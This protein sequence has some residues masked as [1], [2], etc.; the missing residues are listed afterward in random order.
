[1]A[2]PTTSIEERIG[3]AFAGAEA[4]SRFLRWFS[5]AV[6]QQYRTTAS[7]RRS[8]PSLASRSVF[9]THLQSVAST[10]RSDVYGKLCEHLV[11]L[12]KQFSV[13]SILYREFRSGAIHEH[14]FVLDEDRFFTESGLYFTTTRYVVDPGTRYLN[15][16][17]SAKWL[18]SLLEESL[19]NY[20]ARLVATKKL[21]FPLFIQIA[22]IMSEADYLA[23][24]PSDYDEP[25]FV[26]F[27]LGR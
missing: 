10:R 8:K 4:V 9:L 15:V 5:V 6:Q 11:P 16:E 23:F 18:L 26:R 27:A 3:W 20:T 17:F 22:D 2:R 19:K 21:P 25:A 14:G 1:M 12:V 7:Q 13:G 24:E